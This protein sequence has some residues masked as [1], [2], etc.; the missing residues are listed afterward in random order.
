VAA[1]GGRGWPAR[2]SIADDAERR[3]RRAAEA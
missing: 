2:R 3:R 1:S